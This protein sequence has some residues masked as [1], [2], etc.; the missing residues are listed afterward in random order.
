MAADVREEDV[1]CEL[2][3]RSALSKESDDEVS[4]SLCSTEY[5]PSYLIV[6]EQMRDLILTQKS[7]AEELV[8]SNISILNASKQSFNTTVESQEEKIRCLEATI[9]SDYVPRDVHESL[10]KKL[11]DDHVPLDKYNQLKKQFKEECEK[12]VQTQTRLREVLDQLDSSLH[13]I[14]GLTMEREKDKATFEAG[15]DALRDEISALLKRNSELEE[16]LDDKCKVNSE[17][18]DR[19]TRQHGEIE[20]LQEQKV[21]QKLKFRQK[22]T[23]TEVA[24]QQEAYLNR[25]L[26]GEEKKK[27]K[28]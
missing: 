8:R 16:K 28:R 9:Q 17:L 26:S 3:S 15:Y 13:Q 19:I 20:D 10:Q 5:M 27:T 24:K 25:V 23:E 11:E 2:S 7:A 22:M 6:Q 14:S 18:E 1:K 12:H 21:Q 4:S